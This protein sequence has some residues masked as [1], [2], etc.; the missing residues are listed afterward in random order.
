MT[1][2]CRIEVRFKPRAKNDRLTVTGMGTL[3]IA[4]TSPPVEEKANE[5]LVRLLAKKLGVSKSSI[6]LIRG[7][8]SKSKV[9]AIEGM[10]SEDLM[11]KLVD[12]KL[13][14]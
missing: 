11:K 9:V 14:K 12:P 3:D 10:S 5:H 2:G 8:H 4:V 6:S 7:G 13:S 1:G